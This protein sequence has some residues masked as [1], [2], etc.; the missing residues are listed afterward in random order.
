MPN[1]I[2]YNLSN[3]TL[4][5]KSQLYVN[6]WIATGDFSKGETSVT[7]YWNGITP[8]VG[9]YTIYLNKATQGPSIYVASSDADF[10]SIINKILI[11]SYTTVADCIYYIST[12]GIGMV[13]NRDYPSI[14]TDGITFITDAGSTLSYPVRESTVYTM[15]P[16]F[17]DGNSNFK[18]GTAYVSEY[19][20]GFQFDGIDDLASCSA[21]TG[22]YGIYNTAAF[23]WVMI[24][25]STTTTW[26]ADGGLGGNRSDTDLNYGDGWLM[27]N[28]S[29]TKKVVFHM[30]DTSSPSAVNIGTIIPTDITVP[31]MYVI[32]S[33][34]SNLHKGYV[35]NGSPVSS[36]A[37]ITRAARQHEIIWGKDGF[38]TGTNLKMVSYVQIMYNR[39]LSD[40]EV[41]ALYTA[42]QG[43]FGF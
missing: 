40:T 38:I 39:Q 5:L 26:S 15:D 12:L 23:T 34:G 20:G 9:G 6:W 28:V 14:S 1:A 11:T 36:S 29:G 2:K 8:P 4:A 13:L 3:Q 7:D 32:S 18:N 10:I 31:H 17:N 35:D 30:G 22:S 43:R 33:N 25:R 42:Y 24:C 21:D 41:L 19:G 27:S 37:I 16:T